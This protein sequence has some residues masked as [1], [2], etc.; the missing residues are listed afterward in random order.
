METGAYSGVPFL[1]IVYDGIPG[2]PL[3][4][5]GNSSRWKLGLPLF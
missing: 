5:V 1:A 3:Y 4:I 2:L